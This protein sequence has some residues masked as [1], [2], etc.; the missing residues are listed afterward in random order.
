MKNFDK[1]VDQ[2]FDIMKIEIAKKDPDAGAHIKAAMKNYYE[3]LIY[4][5]V[6]IAV[7]VAIA[8]NLKKLTPV[9]MDHVKDYI[10]SKCTLR[11]GK[12]SG[13]T[14]LPG[15]YFG[16]SIDPSRYSS[17]NGNEESTSTVDFAHGV[18]RPAID[19]T[20][21]VGGGGGLTHFICTNK[22]VKASVREILSRH[23]I[24]ISKSAM[25]ILLHLIEVHV[26][27]ILKDLKSEGPLTMKKVTK[28][29][30]SKTHAIFH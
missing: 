8:N 4:N 27:C 23:S 21:Q 20:M 28:V 12:Q 18:L 26:H 14:S 6:S 24:A 25:N 19:S 7:V 9:H 15:E 2:S 3:V 1:V 5:I 10:K 29:F 11:S 22:D 13:G 30:N 16:Y 17:L